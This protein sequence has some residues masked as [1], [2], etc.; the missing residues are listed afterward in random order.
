LNPTDDLRPERSPTALADR[1]HAAAIHVLRQVRKVDPESGVT[2]ARL[3]ALSV[4]VHA[5]PLRVGDLAEAEQVAVP[6][7]S[8]MVKAMEDEGLVVRRDSPDDGRVVLVRATGRGRQ[9]LE[10]ARARRVEVLARSLASLSARDRARLERG[11]AVLEEV[12]GHSHDRQRARASPPA[13]RAA[14]SSVPKAHPDRPGRPG[15][16]GR[17]E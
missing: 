8:R 10:K 14:G 13:E 7:M 15:R 5:G 3:S 11:V 4:V 6:T 2:A 17:S 16:G 1:L 12:V 9:V